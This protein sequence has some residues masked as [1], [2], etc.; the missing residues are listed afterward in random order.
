[1]ELGHG[2]LHSYVLNKAVPCFVQSVKSLKR[3]VHRKVIQKVLGPEPTPEPAR[4]AP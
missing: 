3:G 4:S 1:M 2:M